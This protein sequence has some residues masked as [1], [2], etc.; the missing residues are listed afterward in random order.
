MR[1]FWSFPQLGQV[2]ATRVSSLVVNNHTPEPRLYGMDSA[3]RNQQLRI[4]RSSWAEFAR[5]RAVNGS[6]PLLLVE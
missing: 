5:I 1:K 2:S 3:V 4:K 6:K